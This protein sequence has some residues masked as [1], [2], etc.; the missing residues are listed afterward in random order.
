MK[1]WIAL[2]LSTIMA[3]SFVGLVGCGEDENP[4]DNKPT[5]V[6]EGNYTTLTAETAETFDA[7]IATVNSEELLGDMDSET[8]GTGL[9]LFADLKVG[10]FESENQYTN[11]QLGADLKLNVATATEDEYTTSVMGMNIKAAGNA[12]LV[13]DSKNT[14]TSSEPDAAPVVE[15]INVNASANA[16]IDN[17]TTYVD[18]SAQGTNKGEELNETGAMKFST[19]E[20]L[21]M[22]MSEFGSQEEVAPATA[23]EGETTESGDVVVKTSPAQELLATLQPYGITVGYEYSE[24]TGLKLKISVTE[25]TLDVLFANSEDAVVTVDKCT[26]DAYLVIDAQGMLSKVSLNA[27][28]KAS[29]TNNGTTSI[30]EISGILV[31]DVGAVTVQIPESL[32]TDTKYKV[33]QLS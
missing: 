21:Q 33:Q 9:S 30:I 28:V 20:L 26:L 11:I 23:V 24:T 6:V 17:L 8:W 5:A 25:T 16:Y 4:P 10:A 12:S 22:I 13:V 27:D 1:K 2:G 18:Y 14:Q 7:A 3:T 31:L 29:I 32:A 15:V 19:L